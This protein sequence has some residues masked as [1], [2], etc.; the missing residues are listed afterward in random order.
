MKRQLLGLILL[1]CM[2]APFLGTFTW[3]KYQKIKVRKELKKQLIAGVDKNELVLL[4]FTLEESRTDLRWEHDK[5]FEYN[6]QMYDV[7][8]KEIRNDTVYYWCWWDYEE[9]GLNRKLQNLITDALGGDL[10]RKKKQDHTLNFYKSLFF[11][12]ISNQ[13]FLPPTKE[14]ASNSFYSFSDISYFL[15]PPVPPPIQG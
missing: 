11:T 6:N 8:E 4:K 7:V 13:N 9:T 10:E 14:I 1:L 3:L 15:S 12:Q 2:A 5:E